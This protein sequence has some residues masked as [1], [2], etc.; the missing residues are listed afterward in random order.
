[1]L[2]KF[3]KMLAAIETFSDDFFHN[4]LEFYKVLVHTPFT[5]SKGTG[6]MAKDNLYM[7]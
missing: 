7:S 1:M 6:Y 2:T 5:T 3:S 4:F